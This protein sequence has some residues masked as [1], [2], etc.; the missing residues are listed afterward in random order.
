VSKILTQIYAKWLIVAII[1]FVITTSLI[2]S[3]IFLIIQLSPSLPTH[4]LYADNCLI[5]LQF[6]NSAISQVLGIQLFNSNGIAMAI[7][8]SALQI[9]MRLAIKRLIIGQ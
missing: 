2:H 6:K 9:V 1:F 4:G 8:I 3:N 5:F 7:P